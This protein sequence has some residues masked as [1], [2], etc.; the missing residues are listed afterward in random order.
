MDIPKEYLI[1]SLA[2]TSELDFVMLPEEKQKVYEAIQ[3]THI[4]GSPDG[5]WFFIIAQGAGKGHHRL[6]GITDTSMLRPQV[7]AYQRGEAAIAFCASEKQ[8]IDA[9]MESLSAEDPRFW[10]RCDRYWN[11]RG[12]SYTDGGAFLFDV[13]KKDD[14]N[15]ELIMTDKFGGLV[16]THPNGD[17]AVMDAAMTSEVEWP[18][19]GDAVARFGASVE[20]LQG[21]D[22]AAAKTMLSEINTY[23]QQVSRTEA[24]TCLQLLLDRCYSTGNLRKSRWL[25]H[26][27]DTLVEILRRVCL[28][29]ARILSDKR[30][31]GTVLNR[32]NR[33]S[34][35]DRRS[36]LSN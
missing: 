29:L 24:I 11:A 33:P 27:E 35:C 18:E 28:H 36:P 34:D 16:D 32:K 21:M 31:Q 2:P 20:A 30:H 22:W 9:V 1:E 8:V 3:K 6:I 14:G 19:D 12:G 17:Y 10:R 7:F 4:H 5:P 26:V 25:D 23:S 15:F 13:T